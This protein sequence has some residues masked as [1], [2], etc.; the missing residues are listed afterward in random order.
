[1]EK[2]RTMNNVD[3]VP[4]PSE[5]QLAQAEARA[6]AT[7]AR[8]GHLR[9][10][11][12]LAALIEQEFAGRIALVSSFGAEAA[13]LL[14]MTAEIDPATPVIFLETG[15]LFGETLKYRD[16]LAD[17]LGL[18]DVRSMTPNPDRA[19]SPDPLG[20]LW[21]RNPDLCCFIR[22]VEPLRRALNGFDAWIT[23]RKRYQGGLRAEL[24]HIEAMAGRVKINPLA[25]WRKLDIDA[26]FAAHDL[27]RHPLEADGYLSIGCVP[28]TDRV[29]P[30]EDMRSSRWNGTDKT[31]CGI[32]LPPGQA[33]ALEV[34]AEYQKDTCQ[35]DT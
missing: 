6:R 32:H 20:N 19:K 3:P 24:P 9:G 7:S 33:P 30:G 34:D 26:Y 15:K 27:P 12:L 18:A 4:Q 28:C 31:E 16:L 25:D 1:M 35:Q 29:A 23:G 17:R 10:R 22:K 11:E 5:E 13:V 8:Y 2:L 14:H 21:A